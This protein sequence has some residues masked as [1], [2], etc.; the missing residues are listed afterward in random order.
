MLGNHQRCTVPSGGGGE[1]CAIRDLT[2]QGKEHGSGFDEP[3][4]GLHGTADE[5]L[6]RPSTDQPAIED[7]RDVVKA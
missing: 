2:G 3:R 5:G 1:K 4:I 6:A 7:Q